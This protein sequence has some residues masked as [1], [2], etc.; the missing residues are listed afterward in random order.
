MYDYGTKGAVTVKNMLS[1]WDEHFVIREDMAYVDCTVLTPEP[2][3]KASGHV[4]KFVD[5]MVKVRIGPCRIS[6]E[7]WN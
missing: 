2:V 3:L 5:F 6:G 4:D 1:V 7:G